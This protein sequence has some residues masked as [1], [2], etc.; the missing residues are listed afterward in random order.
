MNRD[1]RITNNKFLS[2][3]QAWIYR[4]IAT[5]G[6]SVSYSNAIN[7]SIS[8]SIKKLNTQLKYRRIDPNYENSGNPLS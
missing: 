5:P 4:L 2:Q 8:F 3:D 1:T 7:S 6:P